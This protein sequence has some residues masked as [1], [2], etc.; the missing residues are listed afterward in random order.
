MI[1]SSCS[2]NENPIHKD[3]YFLGIIFS[4][5]RFDSKNIN[6]QYVLRL[7]FFSIP[8]LINKLGDKNNIDCHGH[9][10]LLFFQL[11]HFHLQ[12]M[13]IFF[14]GYKIIVF[15]KLDFQFNRVST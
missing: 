4:K 15:F 10:Y 12:A 9:F 13:G 1:I 14:F 2:K 8:I 5:K 7:S 11:F 3:C 6:S